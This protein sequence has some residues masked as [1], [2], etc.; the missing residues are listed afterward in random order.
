MKVIGVAAPLRHGLEPIGRKPC[1]DGRR[2][3]PWWTPLGDRGVPT[4][5]AEQG[6]GSACTRAESREANYQSEEL[7]S[8]W[9]SVTSHTSFCACYG[10]EIR[11]SRTRYWTARDIG[12]RNCW[13]LPEL[14][15]C[16]YAWHESS[17]FGPP[18]HCD[19]C[20]IPVFAG[21]PAVWNNFSP[22][23]VW[24][25]DYICVPVARVLLL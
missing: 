20:T 15:C 4:E 19:L 14:S 5:G 13:C 17:A 11:R 25:L 16:R 3:G 12:T 7:S 23:S 21:V 10:S 1:G 6:R 2:S 8:F 18:W 9:L 22:A 24:T